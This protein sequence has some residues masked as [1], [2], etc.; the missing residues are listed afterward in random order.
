MMKWIHLKSDIKQMKREPIMLLF[1]I[2]SLLLIGV[3]K[4]III[5]GTPLLKKMT[6]FDLLTYEGDVLA[7]VY[8]LQPFMLGTVI[9]FFM[10]DEKDEKIFELLRVTPL[11][12]SGYLVNR[13]LMPIALVIVYTLIAYF[14]LGQGLHSIICLVPIILML[15]LQTIVIGLFIAIVSEDKVKGL[16]YSKAIS[17]LMVFAF[18]HLMPIPWLQTLAKIVPQYYV[19]QLIFSPSIVMMVAGVCVHSLWLFVMMSLAL[20]RL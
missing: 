13:L 9:G 5:F 4:A 8:L 17:G 1:A 15:C 11:G 19:G 6:G 7:L 3:F 12:L 2:L 18:V 14:T 20:K 10:L 16:T